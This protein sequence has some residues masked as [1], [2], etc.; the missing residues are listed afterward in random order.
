MGKKVTLSEAKL[1]EIIKEAV[2]GEIS[3][4]KVMPH[5]FWTIFKS[6]VINAAHGNF[7]EV[8]RTVKEFYMQ[9]RDKVGR[10][11]FTIDNLMDLAEKVEDG[12]RGG[13]GNPGMGRQGMADAWWGINAGKELEES[14]KPVKLNEAKLK[15]IIA[16]SVKRVLM[17][18]SGV[19]E[20]SSNLLSR[21]S[22]KAFKD[23]MRNWDNW[24]VKTKRDKQWHNLSQG[25]ID[26]SREEKDAVCPS[27]PES[28]LKNMPKD[29]YV[30]LD[31]TGR[32]YYGNFMH[33]YDGHAGTEEQCM[34]YV[35]K[36]FDK[37]ADWEF[38]PDIV[39]LDK[40]LKNRARYS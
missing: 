34:A 2:L 30:V 26:R 36:Y 31:G 18:A 22:D 38:L 11:D 37:D 9:F 35:D 10:E 4:E 29:T 21:A 23:M 28:E 13:H 17:E 39:P 27:V 19:N 5:K 8:E 3:R 33:R 20:I 16:E 24:K 1:K 7:G 40:Y 6:R 32:D 14:R 15:N 25:A 12:E